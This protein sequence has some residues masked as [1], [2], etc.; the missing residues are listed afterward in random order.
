MEF[1]LLGKK[2]GHSFSRA[3]FT[4]KFHES[5]L[6]AVYE[7]FELDDI[8][9]FPALC[10]AHPRLRGLNVTIPYKEAILPYLDALSDNA[11][12]IGAVNTVKFAGGKKIGHNTDVVGFREALAAIYEGSPGGNALILGTG[13]S[14]KAVRHVLQHYFEFDSILNATRNPVGEAQIGYP[15]LQEM[16]L[17]GFKLIVHCTPVGMFPNEDECLDLPYATLNKDCLAFDLIYNPEETRF[18]VAARE[19]GC[20]VSNGMDMLILQAEASW[21]IWVG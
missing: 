2:L 11:R 21:G 15:A 14:A 9:G 18:L 8:S 13:G 6:D 17:G 4:H 12:A 1:G 3:Y 7:N 16:G 5:H 10:A 20:R 19:Q